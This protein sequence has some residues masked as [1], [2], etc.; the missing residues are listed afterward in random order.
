MA[1]PSEWRTRTLMTN[2]EVIKLL[3]VLIQTVNTVRQKVLHYKFH[4]LYILKNYKHTEEC[5]IIGP[6]LLPDST[7]PHWPRPFHIY[8]C[9]TATA[10]NK[11]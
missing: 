1:A 4:I 9:I 3:H 11:H 2:E 8:T 5:K 6:V 10:G 7:T